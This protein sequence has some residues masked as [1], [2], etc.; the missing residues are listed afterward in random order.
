MKKN[1]LVSK[2]SKTTISWNNMLFDADHRFELH[3]FRELDYE[4]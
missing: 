2:Y 1:I 3:S 4:Q